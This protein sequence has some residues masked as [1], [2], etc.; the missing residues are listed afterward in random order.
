MLAA[1]RPPDLVRGA[2][3]QS[4]SLWWP[5][6]LNPWDPRGTS[7]FDEQAVSAAPGAPVLLEVGALE[8][9]LTERGRAAAARLETRDALIGAVEH[10]GGHDGRPWQGAID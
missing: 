1:P 7:W 5:A 2:V 8:D 10:P 3:A 6:T 9:V 4:P